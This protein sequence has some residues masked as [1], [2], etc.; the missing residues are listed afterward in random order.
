MLTSE[1]GSNIMITKVIGVGALFLALAGT[2]LQA[3]TVVVG[4]PAVANTGNCDPFGCPAFFGLG[5]YQQVYVGSALPGAITID[6]IAFIQSIIGYNGGS[7]AG[8]TYALDFSY[9]SDAPGTLDLTNFNNNIT[10]GDQN[11]F[12]GT[13]PSLT[14][15]GAEKLLTFNGTPF[16][17]DPSQG[18]LLLTVTVTGGTGAPP[19][20]YLDQSECGPKTFCPAGASVTTSDAYF[21]NYSGGNDTGGLV[22]AFTYTVPSGLSTPEPGSLILVLGGIGLIGY[23]NRRK[24]A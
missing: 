6:G 2:G 24:L 11:F 4:D 14:P 12:T 21:G 16:A 13:L 15:S 22:T 5:T 8:G 10:S 1:A 23:R 20:L 3:G 9:T 19:F 7:P 18:N 17:Y